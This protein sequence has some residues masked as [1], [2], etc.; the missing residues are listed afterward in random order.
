LSLPFF[1]SLFEMHIIGAPGK[2][3]KAGS[4]LEPLE[5]KVVDLISLFPNFVTIKS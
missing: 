1:K 2:S 5:V 4:I 3:R